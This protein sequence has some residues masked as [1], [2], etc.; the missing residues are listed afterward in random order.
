MKLPGWT[1]PA[2][3][4]IAAGALGLFVY[5]RNAKAAS[6]NQGAPASV[7]VNLQPGATTVAVAKGGSVVAVL[8]TGASWSTSAQPVNPLASS[9]VQPSG[10]MNMNVVMPTVAGLYPIL[11]S[12]T[13]SNGQAQTTQVNVSVS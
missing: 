8:P 13:D 7:S 6:P 2:I 3:L 9:G 12:W 5:E 11:F 4:G 1:L 10:T